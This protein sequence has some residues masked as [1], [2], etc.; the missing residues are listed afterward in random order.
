MSNLD[1]Q[2]FVDYYQGKP[3]SIS[4]FSRVNAGQPVV[5]GFLLDLQ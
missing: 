3:Q 5:V 2:D 1:W 4:Y